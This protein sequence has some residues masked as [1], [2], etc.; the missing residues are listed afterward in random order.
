M[1]NEVELPSEPD[2]ILPTNVDKISEGYPDINSAREIAKTLFGLRLKRAPKLEKVL[3]QAEQKLKKVEDTIDDVL[4][5]D[6]H[7]NLI[8]IEAIAVI[9]STKELVRFRKNIQT[10]LHIKEFA[11]PICKSKNWIPKHVDAKTVKD[12]R[13]QSWK[14][15]SIVFACKECLKE[16]R[17]TERMIRIQGIK[18]ALIKLGRGLKDFILRVKRIEISGD[19]ATQSGSATIEVREEKI[20]LLRCPFI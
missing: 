18:Y 1:S 15:F 19:L 8:Y 6:E 5:W 2:F 16:G 7:A 13:G 17:L 14:C 20:K 3:F 4:Y 12:E 9:K 10:K 11:C